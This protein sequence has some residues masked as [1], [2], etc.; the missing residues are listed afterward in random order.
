MLHR[1]LEVNPPKYQAKAQCRISSMSRNSLFPLEMS[2]SYLV[3][4]DLF[5]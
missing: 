2:T 4:T 3:E 1:T 5:M